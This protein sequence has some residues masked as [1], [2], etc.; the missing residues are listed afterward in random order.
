MLRIYLMFA[1]KIV[2]FYLPFSI[3]LEPIE[4]LVELPVVEDNDIE[5]AEAII[6]ATTNKLFSSLKLKGAKNNTRVSHSALVHNYLVTL[7]LRDYNSLKEIAKLTR[8]DKSNINHGMRSFMGL[9]NEVINEET[10]VETK[11][12][13]ASD[14]VNY[15]LKNFYNALNLNDDQ[16]TELMKLLQEWNIPLDTLT[17]SS[18]SSDNDDVI[19]KEIE[20]WGECTSVHKSDVKY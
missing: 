17:D 15:N 13:K 18:T 6:R 2:I 12:V 5:K 16:P 20:V 4:G 9:L 8:V 11:S 14:V 19:F 1:F 10:E 7:T 3:F